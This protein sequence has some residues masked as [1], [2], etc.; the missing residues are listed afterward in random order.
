MIR[1]TASDLSLLENLEEKL[2]A[3]VTVSLLAETERE[4]L[5]LRSELGSGEWSDVC[6][7][8]ALRPIYDVLGLGALASR[9]LSGREFRLTADVVEAA[10]KN[11]FQARPSLVVSAAHTVGAW[12]F[13]LPA[14]RSMRARKEYFAREIAETIRTVVK[15]RIL[16]LG[17]NP[18]PE[19]EDAVE[20]AHL[21]HAQF[22]A[23]DV[24]GRGAGEVLRLEQG[25]WSDLE[26]LSGS[27]GR[28]DLIYSTAWLDSTDDEQAADWLSYG[29]DMLRTDGRLLA[30]NFA[31][32]SRDAGWMEAC[33]N[34]HPSYRDEEDLARLVMNLRNPGIRGH[35]ISRDESGASAYLE[36]YSL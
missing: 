20:G 35:A 15:P 21:H 23:V 33:W 14:S 13:S 18:W 22:V 2:K 19:A 6:A 34:W 27:L 11:A 1:S 36:L 3:D 9:R 8:F 5:R 12:E 30:A 16:I 4:L 10:M 25:D 28:F 17:G 26:R 29:I 24:E 7:T 32:G 31:P